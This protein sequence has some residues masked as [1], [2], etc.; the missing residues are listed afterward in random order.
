MREV[1]AGGVQLKHTEIVSDRSAPRLEGAQLKKTY[2]RR[3]LMESIRTPR[4]LSPVSSENIRNRS[5]PKIDPS[6]HIKM[7]QR[8]PFLDNVLQGAEDFY[9]RLL[10]TVSRVQGTLKNTRASLTSSAQ[11]LA[12]NVKGTTDFLAALLKDTPASRDATSA[13]RRQLLAEIAENRALLRK[14]PSGDIKDRSKPFL[15]SAYALE[16]TRKND[17]LA[18]TL[19]ERHSRLLSEI[20]YKAVVRSLNHVSTRDL[21]KPAISGQEHYNIHKIDRK[22]LLLEVASPE[23][24]QLHSVKV[25][26]KSCPVLP[27]GNI[28]FHKDTRKH[29]CAEVKEG[30]ELHHPREIHDRSAAALTM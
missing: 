30:V 1:M 15:P 17:A 21:S 6:V 24:H 12:S 22:A 5:A 2:N 25:C 28:N 4:R 9:N 14:T 19:I 29:L 10:G 16:Q 20:R 18:R 11:S 13:H 23:A 27:A 7:V 26:D 8:R 3:F